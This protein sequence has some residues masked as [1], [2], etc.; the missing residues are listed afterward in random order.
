MKMLELKREENFECGFIDPDR[1]HE[2]TIDNV[3]FNKETPEI[4]VNYFKRHRDKKTIFWPYN[5]K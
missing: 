4:L 1:L 3:L 5:F 2:E